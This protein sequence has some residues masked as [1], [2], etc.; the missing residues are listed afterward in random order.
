MIASTAAIVVP[1]LLWASLLNR[2]VL[3]AVTV[4]LADEID[5]PPGLM[6][7]RE[8]DGLAVLLDRVGEL[9]EVCLV[10]VLG[11]E[12]RQELRHR[13]VEQQLRVVNP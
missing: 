11:G 9:L 3:M 8:D 10:G 12:A 13:G 6:D 1:T 5:A 2:Y 7:F 4:T